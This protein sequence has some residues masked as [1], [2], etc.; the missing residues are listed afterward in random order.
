MADLRGAR[1]ARPRLGLARSDRHRFRA[2]PGLARARNAGAVHLR[3]RARLLGARAEPRGERLVQRPR[4]PD[5][6]LQPPL[7]GT[8]RAGPLGD[9]R[10]SDGV[11]PREGAER[12]RH[13]PRGRT[14]LAPRPARGRAVAL[15]PR[16]QRSPWR[17]RRSPTRRRSSPRTSSTR[18][19]SSSRGR[20]SGCSSDRRGDGS[21]SWRSR[22][23]PP[24]R[25]ARRRSGSSRP[26]CSRRL[27]LALLGRERRLLRPFARLYGAIAGLAALVVGVQLA[28][29]GSLSDLLGAYSVVG[30]GGYDLG[31]ALRFWLWHVEELTLYVAVVPVVVLVVLLARGPRL[32]ERLREHVAATVALVVTSTA[33][34][35]AFASRFAPDRVQDRYLFFCAPLLLVA[36][37]GW[38]EIGAPRPRR[39]ARG[40]QRARARARVRL[41]VH[42]VHRRARQVG[43]VRPD[44][45]LDGERVPP[46]RLLPGHRARRRARARRAGRVRAGASDR[47]PSRSS[48]SA[49]SSSSRARSGRGRTACSARARARSSR[50]SAASSATG[51]T[52]APTARS[53]SSGPGAPTGSRST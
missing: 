29:G 17:C 13:V 42:P 50:A 34:V 21:A 25:H 7:P 49:S 24:S 19:R 9:G 36:V 16:G 52:R 53:P 18:S 1:R 26:S 41:S 30:E 2:R 35:G 43:H 15:A 38:I 12:P 6:R 23:P 4:R 14:R 22:W 3:R 8:A 32:P 46:R 40:G 28:R 5:E 33:V 48:C 20:S 31:D 47:S 27:C 10:A 44:P 39:A 51:S 45:A 37:L 11:R